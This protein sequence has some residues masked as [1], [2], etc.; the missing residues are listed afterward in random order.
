MERLREGVARLGLP[1]PA[2]ADAGVITMSAG[3]AEIDPESVDPNRAIHAADRAMYKAKR[4][5]RNQ[6][7]V[8]A[9]PSRAYGLTG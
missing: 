2:A 7:E 9:A 5:G 8:A 3:V 6:V 1:G 4:L